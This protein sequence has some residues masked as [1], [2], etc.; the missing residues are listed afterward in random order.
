M[1]SRQISK[2][3]ARAAMA[4]V[5]AGLSLLG[6]CSNEARKDGQSAERNGC[7][8]PNGCGANGERNGCGGPNGCGANGG[9]NGC[10]GHGGNAAKPA[11]K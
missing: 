10:G 4:G 6:A 7:G 11:A 5:L 8:G 2:V 1:D 9:R 3:A